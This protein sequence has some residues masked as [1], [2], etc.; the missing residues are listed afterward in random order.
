[1]VSVTHLILWFAIAQNNFQQTNKTE[2]NHS[3]DNHIKFEVSLHFWGIWPT[4]RRAGLDCYNGEGGGVT[5]RRAFPEC[6][7]RSYL[8]PIMIK[9]PQHILLSASNADYIF[10]WQPKYGA[11]LCQMSKTRQK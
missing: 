7:A 4:V 9:I 8:Q 10:A 2:I 6:R 11:Q 5:P 3:I 1:M